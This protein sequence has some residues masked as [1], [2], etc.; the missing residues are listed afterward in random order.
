MG[1]VG[2]A[3]GNMDVVGQN[4]DNRGETRATNS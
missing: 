1:E 3:G 4:V 2:E